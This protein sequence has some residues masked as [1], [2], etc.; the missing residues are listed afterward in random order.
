[1]IHEKGGGNGKSH[2]ESLKNKMMVIL[3][4]SVQDGEN[5]VYF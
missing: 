1:M 5:Q 3:P 4:K 2:I